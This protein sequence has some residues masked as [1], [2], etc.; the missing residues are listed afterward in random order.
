MLGFSPFGEKKSPWLLILTLLGTFLS[1]KSSVCV[2]LI[3]IM[4]RLNKGFIILKKHL[5]K[6]VFNVWSWDNLT[7]QSF[8]LIYHVNKGYCHDLN[9]SPWLEIQ[10]STNSMQFKTDSEKNWSFEEFD[11]L[12]QQIMWC[13]S[14][15]LS[16]YIIQFIP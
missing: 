16:R 13:L 10:F 15:V 12:L 7:H 8:L 1:E 3:K 11:F 9:C 4:G 6:P 5:F 14:P 2:I